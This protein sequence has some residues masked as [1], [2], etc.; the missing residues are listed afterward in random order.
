MLKQ[1]KVK[2]PDVISVVPFTQNRR[3]K[4]PYGGGLQKG[5]TPDELLM[6][7]QTINRN[8]VTLDEEGNLIIDDRLVE[9]GATPEQIASLEEQAAQNE[10]VAQQ[11]AIQEKIMAEDAIANTPALNNTRYTIQ[12]GDTLGAIAQAFGTDYRTIAEANGISDPNKIIAGKTINIPT[13]KVNTPGHIRRVYNQ[14]V[15]AAAQGNTP[16]NN[17]QNT[18]TPPP[19]SKI[20]TNTPTYTSNTKT[21]STVNYDDDM[22]SLIRPRKEENVTSDSF[23]LL[24][25]IYKNPNRFT[26]T[27]PNNTETKN[28]QFNKHTKKEQTAR[29]RVIERHNNEVRARE[30]EQNSSFWSRLAHSLNAAEQGKGQSLANAMEDFAAIAQRKDIPK[31]ERRAA[32]QISNEI[33]AGASGFTTGT[34]TGLSLGTL[35]WIPTLLGT[36]G[37]YVGGEVGQKISDNYAQNKGYTNYMM[38]L[39]EQYNEGKPKNQQI[40]LETTPN[41]WAVGGSFAGGFLGGKG[42]YRATKGKVNTGATRSKKTFKAITEESKPTDQRTM[43]TVETTKP[44]MEVEYTPV[45]KSMS[46]IRAQKKRIRENIK[47]KN[48]TNENNSTN[49]EPKPKTST[50]NKTDK[51]IAKER[52]ERIKQIREEL[53]EN[54]QIAKKRLRNI[55][56][57]RKLREEEFNPKAVN[58]GKEINIS[59]EE[60]INE[61]LAAGPEKDVNPKNKTSLMTRIRNKATGVKNSKAETPKTETKKQTRAEKKAEKKIEKEAKK[62]LKEEQTKAAVDA[63]KEELRTQ[64]QTQQ[65]TQQPKQEPKPEPKQTSSNT[66]QQ[67]QQ[68]NKPKTAKDVVNKN[69]GKDNKKG[70]KNKKK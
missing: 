44:S 50:Q 68:N 8:P 7:Q 39:Q 69:K 47:T 1:I 53:R 18:S 21:T 13:T 6:L 22:F 38:M 25:Y 19:A 12:P 54:K 20:T 35:G 11:A 32:Q 41:P 48:N 34:M 55:K 33:K 30:K 5:Y 57:I 10:I 45:K 58:E 24:K 42:G 37:S 31:D 43:S 70:K 59:E 29:A 28:I 46:E 15:R 60:L 56:K 2:R 63:K 67:T 17:T 16:V 3:V 51:Q 49:T 9:S 27:N 14:K 52:L 23:D 66:Q 65:Q 4:R 64:Q 36:A 62:Q 40:N 26:N 61:A